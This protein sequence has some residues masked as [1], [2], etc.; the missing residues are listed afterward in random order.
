MWTMDLFLIFLYCF[1]V[2]KINELYKEKTK[3]EISYHE[4]YHKIVIELFLIS[5]NNPHW[6][7]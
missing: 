5:A 4:L 3:I 1:I 2:D 6:Y 7:L